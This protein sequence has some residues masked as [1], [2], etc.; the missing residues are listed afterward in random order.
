MACYRKGTELNF[1]NEHTIRKHARTDQSTKHTSVVPIFKKR[2]TLEDYKLG[3]SLGCTRRSCLEGEKMRGE[4]RRE[5]NKEVEGKKSP[6]KNHLS[7][8]TQHFRTKLR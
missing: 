2:P 6:K 5:K 7:L 8:N 3:A 1:T 4:K